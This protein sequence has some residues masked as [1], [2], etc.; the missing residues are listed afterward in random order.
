MGLDAP[1]VITTICGVRANF[2]PYKLTDLAG[3]LQSNEN[4]S[5]S[6]KEEY[7]L[8]KGLDGDGILDRQ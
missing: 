8:A 5:P 1:E 7:P 3:R 2:T 4:V 6:P